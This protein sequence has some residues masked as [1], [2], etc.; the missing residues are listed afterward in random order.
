MTSN[1]L[2]EHSNWEVDSSYTAAD[3]NNIKNAAVIIVRKAQDMGIAVRFSRH[4]FDQVILKRGYGKI[5]HHMLMDAMAKF[6]TRGVKT[7]DDDTEMSSYAFQDSSSQLILEVMKTERGDFLVRTVIRSPRWMGR[8]E[9]VVL[10]APPALDESLIAKGIN[11][12][13]INKGYQYLGQ[14]VD[15]I[16]YLEPSTGQVLKIFGADKTSFFESSGHKMFKIWADYCKH[17]SNNPFLPKYSGWAKFEFDG[18]TYLQIRMEQLGK[19]PYN[20]DSALGELAFLAADSDI[21]AHDIM[22]SVANWQNDDI[23]LGYRTLN[24]ASAL[25][26]TELIVHVGETGFVQLYNTIVQL[27]TIARKYDWSMDLHN[28]NFL[29]RN[30]GT[31]VI[32]DPWRA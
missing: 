24:S 16:A 14:G 32:V 5:D 20:W 18:D 9:K 7:F 8:S 13:L 23:T 17:N 25:A 28:D 11:D 21:T 29:I 31:P 30:D 10:E 26:L 6:L 3:I 19:F 12:T 15:Q 2:F 1:E 4:F 27:E 22:T